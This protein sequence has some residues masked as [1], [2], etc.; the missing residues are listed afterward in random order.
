[1]MGKSRSS[2]AK[3]Q[4]ANGPFLVSALCL[5]VLAACGKRLPV[6][7]TGDAEVGVPRRVVVEMFTATWCTNCPAADQAAESLA[8]ELGD[9]LTLIEYHPTFGSPLD[10]FGT[11]Q[12]EQRFAHY[13]VS[14][15]PVFVCDGVARVAGAVPNLL[16]E[17]RS[18]AIARL[19]K[20]SPVSITLNGGLGAASV[21]YSVTVSSEIEDRIGGLRLLLVLVEDSI[22]YAAPNGV[23]LH[24]LVARRLDPD[25][26][27]EVFS[28]EPGS[29]HTRNGSIALE[30]SWVQERL[31]LTAI[32][33]DETTGELLQSAWVKLFQA[34]YAIQLA[35]ADTLLDGQA[36]SL[37]SFPFTIRNIGNM[38]D[39]M[40]I[41]LPQ[42]LAV[43]ETLLATIC[44]RQFCYPLPLKWYIP[45]SD[46]LTS[47]EVHITPYGSGRSTAVLTV[48]PQSSPSDS[49][50]ARFHVEVP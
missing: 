8:E 43:P 28:L 45:A 29:Q 7:A 22:S 16:S 38:A 27:G 11:A 1:M 24:R 26:P 32:V 6:A 23:S 46:S 41:D 36:N 40:I 48:K 44:D 10:P 17:Y 50:A 30:P 42:S 13:G 25:N 34:E 20:S 9:S 21:S 2:K 12:T 33:Q 3:S 4:K 19:R 5:L 14:A 37:V 39:T 15:P 35:A 18:A 47:L 49:A 31:G